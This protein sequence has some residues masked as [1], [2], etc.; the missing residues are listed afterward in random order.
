MKRVNPFHDINSFL[1][2]LKILENQKF[3]DFS[4]G[5]EKDQWHEM[6]EIHDGESQILNILV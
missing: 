1:Y 4:G 6:V 3:S 2:P 5:T